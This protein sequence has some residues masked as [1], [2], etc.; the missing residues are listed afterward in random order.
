MG[1]QHG[2]TAWVC[3]VSRWRGLTAWGW[4]S[5]GERKLR[6]RDVRVESSER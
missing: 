6:E 1:W 2:S 4:A 5:S 3:G